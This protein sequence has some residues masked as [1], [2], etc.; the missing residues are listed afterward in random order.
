MNGPS[1]LS[2]L[3]RIAV[4]EEIA[5][6]VRHD[7][8]NRFSA[9][10][11]AAFYLRRKCEKTDVWAED[12]RIA[13]FFELIQD[14]LKRAD[15]ILTEGLQLAHLFPGDADRLRLEDAV[16]AALAPMSLPAEVTTRV[17]VPDDVVISADLREIVLLLHCLVDNAI[18]AMEDGGT[19]TVGAAT[20][21]EWITLFVEDTGRGF[22]EEERSKAL[23]PLY[24][25]KPGH[26]GLGLNIA[27]RAARRLDGEVS[28]EDVERGAKVSV[29]FPRA[30]DQAE[31]DA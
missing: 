12:A 22:G 9:I 7:L 10:R 16:R 18:D 3:E 17:E 31:E 1:R 25:S 14:E 29:R 11:N 19:L 30:G 13:Q 8:R 5:S 27:T 20:S 2:S 24:S 21:D 26:L 28:I 15:E 23:I 6:S 4:A